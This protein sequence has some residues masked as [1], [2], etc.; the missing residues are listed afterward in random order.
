[1]AGNV[2]ECQKNGQ[3]VGVRIRGPAEVLGTIKENETHPAELATNRDTH[4]EEN[5][6]T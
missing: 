6:V 4:V 2:A 3:L 5:W 1:M